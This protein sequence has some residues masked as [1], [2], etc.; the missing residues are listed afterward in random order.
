MRVLNSSY[1]LVFTD[2]AAEVDMVGKTA[3][4]KR[5]KFFGGRISR[6][7]VIHVYTVL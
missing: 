6:S 2:N 1:E 5:P 7:P 3:L 4:I